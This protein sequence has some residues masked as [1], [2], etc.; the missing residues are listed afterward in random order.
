[1]ITERDRLDRLDCTS[2]LPKSIYKTVHCT[3]Y[4]VQSTVYSL[5]EYSVHRQCRAYY[6]S[7]S[8]LF[9]FSIEL[10]HRAREKL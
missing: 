4:S 9:V 8:V 3:L 7:L 10:K 5:T 1:M 6:E 2:R